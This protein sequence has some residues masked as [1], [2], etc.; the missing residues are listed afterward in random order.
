[1]IYLFYGKDSFS[2]RQK[3]FKLLSFSQSKIGNL[4]IF[5]IKTEDFNKEKFDFFLKSQNLFSGKSIIICRDLLDSKIS[6]NIISE[7]IEKCASSENIFF[8]LEEE[9]KNDILELIESKSG[10]VQK[11]ENLSGVNLKKW[12]DGEIQKRGAKIPSASQENII[13][14]CGSDLWCISAQI[15]L[16]ILGGELA[17]V[18]QKDYNPFQICDAVAE[19]DR[20]SA[21]ILLQKAILS[22]VP[23]EEVFWKI[24]W[25][26][27]VLLLVKNQPQ[28]LD[29]HP[30][31]IKKNLRNIKN[32][33]Q[34]ELKNLSWNLV[35]LYHKTRQGQA[36][37]EIGLEKIL[38]S[39]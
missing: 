1:M 14:N 5:E 6:A 24:W 15:D 13:K 9:I 22:G 30:F 34:E 19:K 20:K 29:L 8:F 35:D 31:V 2:M 32:F 39:L 23:V 18:K 36:E 33:T 26:V 7:N 28:D 21:W 27:K 12:L 25:Q 3:L 11:F 17:A 16:H 4:G 37:F 38:I 10:K